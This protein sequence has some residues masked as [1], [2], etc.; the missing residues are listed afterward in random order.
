MKNI[1]KIPL[2]FALCLLFAL[3]GKAQP[4][5]TKT[6]LPQP[7]SHGDI[8]SMNSNFLNQNSTVI[9]KIKTINTERLSNMSVYSNTDS[10][11]F[12][13]E[14]YQRGR[15]DRER[16]PIARLIVL[17]GIITLIVVLV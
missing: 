3:Y 2:T 15:G 5:E 9:S 16:R 11:Q 7:N 8:L 10:L 17:A 1:K 14:Y 6:G 13:E 4:A 12:V